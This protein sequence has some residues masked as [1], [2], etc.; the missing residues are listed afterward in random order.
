MLDNKYSTFSMSIPIVF[1]S[2][3]QILFGLVDIGFLSYC[4]DTVV[5]LDMQTK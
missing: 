2:F 5:R 4:S 3:F 1:Q